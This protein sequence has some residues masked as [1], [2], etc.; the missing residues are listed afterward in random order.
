VRRRV[1]GFVHLLLLGVAACAHVE[2]PPGGAEDREPP[3]LLTSRP[4]SLAT[5]RASTTPVVLVFDERISERGLN[6][7]VMVSPRTSMVRV[8][9][10]R[11]ELRVSLRD[12]WEAGYV[13]QITVL[14]VVQDLFGNRRTEPVHFVFSTGPEIVDTRMTGRVTDRITGRSEAGVR[15]EAIRMADSLVYAVQSDTAGGFVFARVP[16]GEYRIRAFQDMN[17]NR[18]LDEFEPRDTIDVTIATTDTPSV[19]LAI[20]LPDT[21]PPAIASVSVVNEN[22]EIRFDDHLD[23]DQELSP[24]RL[25]VVAEDGQVVEILEVGVGGLASAAEAATDTLPADTAG[26]PVD[27]ARAAQPD[28]A[29]SATT[30]APARLPSQNLIARLADRGALREGVEYRVTVRAVRN[31]NGLTADSEGGFSGPAPLVEEEPE[32]PGAE[33]STDRDG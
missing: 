9:H 27:P 5:V 22:L 13:Y 11:D 15:V 29:P 4:D 8:D 33:V 14:P 24:D 18:E 28:R 16:E 7:A 32:D 26:V 31:V 19:A 21:T 17:R 6:D 12:G 25:L 23:P 1:P 2:P 20:L 3:A 30:D 10:R